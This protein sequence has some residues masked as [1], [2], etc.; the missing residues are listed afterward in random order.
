MMSEGDFLAGLDDVGDA[1]CEVGDVDVGAREGNEVGDLADL[2][3]A[4]CR[5]H[6]PSVPRQYELWTRAQRSATCRDRP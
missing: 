5:V 3:G 4:K 6:P 2:D 1:G